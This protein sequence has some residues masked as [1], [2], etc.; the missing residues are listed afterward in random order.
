MTG[1]CLAVL[2]PFVSLGCSTAPHPR[3]PEKSATVI[4]VGP[5]PA[6]DATGHRTQIQQCLDKAGDRPAVFRFAPG[7]YVL[8]DAEGL[9]IP[10]RA[11]LLMDGARFL[12]A[13]DIQTDGQ[14]FLIENASD[15]SLHGGEIVG[16]RAAWADSTNVA[17]VRA[18]GN[19]QNI[20]VS[21][22]TCR[23]LSSNAVGIFGLGDDAPIRNV[24]LTGVVGINCC[25][26][27]VD[28]LQPNAGPAPGSDRRDQGVVALYHVDGWSVDGCRFEGSRSDGTHFYHCRNGLFTNCSVTGSQ[29]GGYFIEGCENVL[30]LGNLIS[31]NGSRG[32]TIE[33]DSRCCTLASCLVTRSG[34]EGLWMP[35]VCSIIVTGNIFVENGQKDDGERDCEIR[36][37][38][39]DRYATETRDIRIEGNIFRT[40]AHQTAV[41]HMGTG[42]TGVVMGNNTFEGPAPRC[43]LASNADQP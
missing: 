1:R 41:V 25:N 42:V 23:D 39:T 8:T 18:R 29:M 37:D 15:V 24:S 22:L 28:Y 5:F 13:E 32:V 19:V 20:R 35:D 14:A 33:R 27:Y 11:S 30:A 31:D 7:D 16:S 4:P 9:R 3:L 34:R 17:G 6:M 10:A 2:L 12:L 43:H 26:V 36:L 40:A 38:N 21:N